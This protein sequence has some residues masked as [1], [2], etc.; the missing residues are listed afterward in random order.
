MK[1]CPLILLAMTVGLSISAHAIQI[2]MKPGL[3]EHSFKFSE[4]SLS[5]ATGMQKEQMTHAM[6]EMKKQMAN[7]PPEQRKMMEDMMARQGIKLTDQ[8]IEMA[9]QGVKI[10]KDGTKVKACIT[11]AEIDKGEMP[12]VDEGCEQSITQVSPVRLKVSY[13]CKG[14]HPSRGEGEITFQSNKSYTG[15]MKV[16][17][18]INNKEQVIEGETTGKWLSADCGNIKPQSLKA[19]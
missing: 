4:D 9:A 17:S 13:A 1:L 3:W 5:S 2:D 19:N 7:L 16:T 18:E 14:E 10:S 8:G 11:Q 12:Q 6:D 15:K